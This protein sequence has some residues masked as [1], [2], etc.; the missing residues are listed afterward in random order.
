MK[1]NP[2]KFGRIVDSKFFTNIKSE[3]IQFY[4][5]MTGILN[6]FGERINNTD[7]KV[8]IGLSLQGGL[9]TSSEFLLFTGIPSTSTAASS[10]ERLVNNG[11]LLKA[12]LKYDIEDPFFKEW[13]IRKRLNTN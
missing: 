6:V 10:L 12:G 3:S 8:L 7:K 5:I 1:K 11:T 13:I 4:Q 9:P 2:F